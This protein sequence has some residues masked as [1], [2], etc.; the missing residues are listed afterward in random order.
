MLGSHLLPLADFHDHVGQG[1]ERP[2]DVAAFPQGEPLGH[3]LVGAFRPC[4][5]DDLYLRSSDRVARRL[6]I[7]VVDLDEDA[8]HGVRARALLVALRLR[9]VSDLLA[10]LEHLLDVSRLSHRHL[11]QVLH[12]HFA[13]LVLPDFQVA[14]RF[15]E[16]IIDALVVDLEVAD[17][18]SDATLDRG[19]SR[20][21]GRPRNVV[22]LRHVHLSVDLH[23]MARFHASRSIATRLS[24]LTAILQALLDALRCLQVCEFFEESRSS[25][26]YD[27]RLLAAMTCTF[28]V[29]AATDGEG[30]SR[31]G[32]PVGEDR[33]VV[34]FERVQDHVS[35]IGVE[36]LTCRRRILENSVELERFLLAQ[37]LQRCLVN[38]DPRAFLGLVVVLGGLQAHA[39]V[40]VVV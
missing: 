14:L 25:Q 27:A 21:R 26:R 33:Q 38:F 5:V 36:D 7:L 34:A 39:D 17:F 6:H 16:Q 35:Q 28:G 12:E 23:R 40:D 19:L 24:R 4:Q 29:A 32:L 20:R 30:L 2:V 15:V 31:V 9:H 11:G 22:D 3:R 8:E 1:E 18:H 10:V 13:A 37:V